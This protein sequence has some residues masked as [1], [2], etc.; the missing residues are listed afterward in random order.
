MTICDRCGKPFRLGDWPICDD[1]SGK[2]GH[3][4]GHGGT[5]IQAIHPRERA[6]IYRNPA[7]GEIRTPPRADTPM[8]ETYKA[9]GFERVE[10]DTHQRRRELEREGHMMEA[11]YYDNG[12]ATADRELERALGPAL[13]GSCVGADDASNRLTLKDLKDA[14]L[15]D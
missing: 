6:V 1:G 7:T 9:A 12:S 2:H 10:I 14:G 11:A 5:F 15:Q 8:P 4:R 3:S 13:D